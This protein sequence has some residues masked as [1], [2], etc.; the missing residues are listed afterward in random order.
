M[1]E[2]ITMDGMRA[3]RAG[4]RAPRRQD[5]EIILFPGVFYEY[6]DASALRKKVRNRKPARRPKG[7]GRGRSSSRKP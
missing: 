5:A 7:A 2:I 3:A 6:L 1:A 4:R